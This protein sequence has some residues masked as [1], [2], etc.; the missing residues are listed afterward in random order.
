M[1]CKDEGDFWAQNKNSDPFVMV[2]KNRYELCEDLKYVISVPDLCDVLFLVGPEKTPVYGIR[3]ILATRSRLMYQMILRSQQ[4]TNTVAK[5]TSTIKRGLKSVKQALSRK[6]AS[7]K[8][9]RPSP[10]KV[11]IEV[12]DFEVGVF[13]RLMRYI[14]CGVVA[15]DPRTVAGMI[16]AAK[17]FEF[18]DLHDACWEF[19][20]ECMRP[21]TLPLMVEGATLYSQF[22]ET[23]KLMQKVI[24]Y[25]GDTPDV[26]QCCPEIQSLIPLRS[27][28]FMC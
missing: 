21:D 7:P 24:S 28:E 16:N 6:K 8:T 27:D 3:A 22:K 2:L 4:S 17:M 20:I 10:D 26:I 18:P 5:E 19:A 25:L 1:T 14:H 12:K 11:T 9:M 23:R 15:V 13:E